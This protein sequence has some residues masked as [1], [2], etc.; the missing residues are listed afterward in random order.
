MSEFVQAFL[1]QLKHNAGQSKTWL[2]I[3]K[4]KIFISGNA[5]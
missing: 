4:C 5:H 1:N 3:V 2:E